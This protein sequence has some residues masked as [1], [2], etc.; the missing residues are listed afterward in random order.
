MQCKLAHSHLLQNQFNEAKELYQALSFE[1]NKDHESY[2]NIILE[3]FE[4]LKMDG[5]V[6]P[7][8]PKIAELIK[9]Y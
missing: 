8:M 6:H 7:D 3:D 9:E 5:I 1:K 2:K 4:K